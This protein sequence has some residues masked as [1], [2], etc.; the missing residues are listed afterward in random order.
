MAWSLMLRLWRK[1]LSFKV[2]I[3]LSE[4]ESCSVSVAFNEMYIFYTFRTSRLRRHFSETQEQRVR[5]YVRVWGHFILF[6]G[7]GERPI[8]KYDVPSG[9]HYADV[10][11]LLLGTVGF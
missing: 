3:L 6:S 1:K 10:G 11:Q 2:F 4:E 5:V 8:G 7:V 9:W